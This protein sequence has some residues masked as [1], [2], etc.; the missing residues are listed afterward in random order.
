MLDLSENNFEGLPAFVY[1]NSN[2][3]RLYAR[4]NKITGMYTNKNDIG[5]NMR[6]C[7]FIQFFEY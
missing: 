7:T 6:K 5:H 4:D 2:L 1:E 3:K